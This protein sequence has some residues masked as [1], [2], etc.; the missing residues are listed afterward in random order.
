MNL[1]KLMWGAPEWRPVAL[2]CLVLAMV[3]VF[4]CYRRARTARSVRIQGLLLKL[5][6]ITLLLTCILEPLFSGTRPRPGANDF[7]I[8]ADN[9]KSLTIRRGP[10]A[11]TRGT[12]MLAALADDAGWTKRLG[13]DFRVRRYR[14]DSHLEPVE[15]FESL[16][17]N[18]QSSA[19]VTSLTSLARRFSRQPVAG[20]L[21]FCDGNPTDAGLEQIDWKSLPPVFPVLPNTELE[22]RDLS[23]Q[24]VS[25]RD[26][27]FETA[28]VSISAKVVAHGMSDTA[29]VVELRNEKQQV[30][31][32]K[33][34]P[35]VDPNQGTAI[36][37][38]VRPETTGVSFYTLSVRS[39]GDAAREDSDELTM[40]N[41]QHLVSVDRGQGPYRIL[42]IGG[43]P[44]WE[45]KYL[46]RAAQGDDE[47]DLV[48]LLRVAKKE[49][50]FE[51]RSR[52]G[53]QTN[54]LFRGFDSGDDDT[55]ED[56]SEPVLIRLGTRDAEELQ[57]GFPATEEEL[58]TYHAIMLDDVE[59]E[60]F[61]E[62]QMLL[63]RRFVAH[64]GGGFMMLGGAESFSQGN[65]ARTPVEEL[66]PVYSNRN[67]VPGQSSRYRIQLTDEGWIEP[68]MRVRSSEQAERQRLDAMPGF[69]TLNR[70]R[71]IKPGATVLAEA[72]S[73]ADERVPA[74]VAQRFGR[75]RTAALLIGDMWHWELERGP[76]E[77]HDLDQAWRQMLR[78]LVAEV[79]QQIELDVQ[80]VEG[81]D[82]EAVRISVLVRDEKFAPLDNAEV[83]M[84]LE[85][86]GG[87]SIE[88]QAEPSD[89]AGTY[90]CSYVSREAGAYRAS[91]KVSGPD[92]TAIGEK[93]TGWVSQ[94]EVNEFANLE[95][96]VGV[97]EEIAR[98]S[99]GQV[100]KTSELDDFVTELNQR[101][102][103]VVEPW[104]Y[105]LWHHWAMLTVI[106]VC[107]T[108]EWG[109]RRIRGLP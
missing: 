5:V 13:Q 92:G 88:L 22:V 84:R 7:L 44:N 67:P 19:L 106:L 74:L 8:L 18:G 47:V 91:V 80:P 69:E 43:R 104:I 75:G 83:V 56:Y 98:K 68:W 79:P 11:E 51:F 42:Y 100:I 53:E 64:R 81:R 30:I 72:L 14:F 12:E 63:L 76:A 107:L 2:G 59:A 37:F 82:A 94:P 101:D 54:P 102:V 96:N 39:E 25:V 17:F 60:F 65:Y 48:G 24:Q 41:N 34:I 61:T 15:T 105:P 89:T 10:D 93:E 52:R 50:K 20:L 16:E 49:P 35:E 1:S 62:D 46:R 21:L 71:G 55:N 38:E 99:G 108:G 66:L 29:V 78:W 4:W 31:Q 77:P 109:L 36:R 40:A 33:V 95:V 58:F 28:P 45:F 73:P 23:L 26:T 90:E 103:P 87:E 86:P 6:A 97:L 85:S 32:K 9:S 3:L 27:N 57:K 70:I